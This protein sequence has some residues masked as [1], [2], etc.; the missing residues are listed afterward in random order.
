VKTG[1]VAIDWSELPDDAL[2][3]VDMAPFIY[4]F[5]DDVRYA[6][7]FAGLFEQ[8]AAGR[9]RIALSTLTLA[10]VL[11]GPYGHGRDALGKQLEA[12][13]CEFDVHPLSA[14][15]AVEAARLRARYRVRLPDA[16]QLATA[17]EIGAWGLVTHDRDF[18]A[19]QDV[20]VLR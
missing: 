2:L 7:R 17:L 14:S 19:V 15:I 13:L 18:S 3:L 11:T 20:R 6:G 8:A 12:A 1:R 10:E 5:Q 4:H 16:I 9:L